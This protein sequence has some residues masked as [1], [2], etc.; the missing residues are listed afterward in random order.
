MRPILQDNH[1]RRS[2]QEF[3]EEQKGS[4]QLVISPIKPDSEMAGNVITPRTGMHVQDQGNNV[5]AS[6]SSLSQRNSNE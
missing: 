1:R 3:A 6:I 2:Q 5:S 4:Y